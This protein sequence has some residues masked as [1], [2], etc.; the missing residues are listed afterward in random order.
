MNRVLVEVSRTGS[1]NPIINLLIVSRLQ[2]HPIDINTVDK[3]GRT[4]LH[5]ACCITKFQNTDFEEDTGNTLQPREDKS[6]GV[7]KELL[8]RGADPNIFDR[9][10]KTPLMY[11][12]QYEDLKIIEDLLSH[13]ADP[14]IEGTKD[15]TCMRIAMGNFYRPTISQDLHIKRLTIINDISYFFPTLKILSL[16]SIQKNRINVGGVSSTLYS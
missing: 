14:F 6:V 15:L 16:R 10:W 3:N 4:A 8:L 13:G 12:V 11:A 2:D 9:S 1:L 5:W 7:V